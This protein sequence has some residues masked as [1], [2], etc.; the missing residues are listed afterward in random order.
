VTVTREP[1]EN[2]FRALTDVDPV[3][4]CAVVLNLLDEGTPV[5]EIATEVL[6][7]AQV[8]VGQMWEQG[9][10]TVADEH[11]ATAVTETALHALTSAVQSMSKQGGQHVLVACAEGEWHPLPARLAATVAMSA[12][13][14]VTVLGPSLPAEHL[15][16][17]L[18]KGD[19]DALALSCTLATNLIGAARCISAAH[20]MD[21][22]VIAGGR[23]FGTTA[24]RAERLG[25]DRWG[26]DALSL[27]QPIPDLLGRT[28]DIPTE[29]LLLDAVTDAT[30]QQMY[31]RVVTAYPQMATM[32]V[33]QQ[34]RSR[35]DLRWITRY[36]GASVLTDDPTVVEDLLLWLVRILTGRVHESV[37]TTSAYLV[38]DV[39][40]RD[41]PQGAQVLR[42]AT[43]RIA[44]SGVPAQS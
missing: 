1:L 40:E 38:A 25:A 17:R 9:L 44:R 3:R 20:E 34:A 36:T 12:G 24:K 21:V 13:A 43:E 22:P 7:P 32:T 5:R 35:E 14:R 41:A 28:T 11:A 33:A 27:L 6:V 39:V 42:E 31:E 16:R 23:A 26:T 37:I 15:R 30:V 29:A 4:A 8:R 10:W 2:Y 18:G 19:V